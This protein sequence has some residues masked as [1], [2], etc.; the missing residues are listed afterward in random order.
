VGVV[1]LYLEARLRRLSIQRW[2]Q[3]SQIEVTAGVRNVFTVRRFSRI[4]FTVQYI[5]LVSYRSIYFDFWRLDLA[6]AYNAVNASGY[7]VVD[8]A[9]F[10]MH[11]YGSPSWQRHFSTAMQPTLTLLTTKPCSIQKTLH[12]YRRRNGHVRQGSGCGRQRIERQERIMALSQ[13]PQL[14]LGL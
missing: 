9:A 14:A 4:I 11:V 12:G 10:N 13:T 3:L 8:L 6:Y 2:Q 1:G 7:N 5:V